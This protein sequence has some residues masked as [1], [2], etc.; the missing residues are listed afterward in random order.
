MADEIT[1]LVYEGPTAFV[2]LLRQML[3]EEGLTVSYEPPEEGRDL[4]G[5]AQLASVVLGVTGPLWPSI[6]R[7]VK[8]FR[9]FVSKRGI[10]AT[11]QGPAEL[12]QTTEERLATLERLLEE[13]TI[14]AEEHA[15]QRR[16]ILE[17]L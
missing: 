5:A 8:R 1:E 9:A 12:E 6:W 16:R 17:E 13:G 11:V 4:D 2:G 3:R 10:P 7:G 15:E 14:T